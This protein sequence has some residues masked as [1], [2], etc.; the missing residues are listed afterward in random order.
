MEQTVQTFGLNA[1]A[2]GNMS[3]RCCCHTER[4]RPLQPRPAGV[5]DTVATEVLV[6]TR[7]AAA[8]GSMVL[9]FDVPAPHSPSCSSSTLPSRV[10]PA[11]L[12]PSP[13]SS[14]RP[15]PLH[16]RPFTIPSTLLVRRVAST[17]SWVS[18]SAFCVTSEESLSASLTSP[19][20]KAEAA[21]GPSLTPYAGKQRLLRGAVWIAGA[22]LTLVVAVVPLMFDEPCHVEAWEDHPIY[23][24]GITPIGYVLGRHIFGSEG[25]P[26]IGELVCVPAVA[27]W[28]TSVCHRNRSRKSHVFR[29]LKRYTFCMQ[30][31][32]LAA[33]LVPW[34]FAACPRQHLAGIYGM[35]KGGFLMTYLANQVC[36]AYM[37][38]LRLELL[39][40]D[41]AAF[42]CRVLARLFSCLA[43]AIIVM[44]PLLSM[45]VIPPWT[46]AACGAALG[47]SYIALQV[48]AICSMLQA[49]F[50]AYQEA[51]MERGSA[52]G[53]EGGSTSSYGYVLRLA[54][55][56]T[57][58]CGSTLAVIAITAVCL[59]SPTALKLAAWI[60]Q[61]ALVL[62]V[63][64]D[65]LLAALCAGV[66]GVFFD[67]EPTLLATGD[68]VEAAR[69]RQVLNALLEAAGAVTGPS[70]TLA[71]LFEGREPEQLLEAA[72]KRFRCIDWDILR[73]HAHLI[74][75]G[76]TLD[77][78]GAA[79]ELYELSKPCLLSACDAFL[80][81][82]W[83]DNGEQKWQ[84]LTEWCEAFRLAQGRSPRLW[85]DKVCIDQADI[86]SDLECLPI[87]LAGCK[88]LLVTCGSTYISRLWCCVELFVYMRMND[89]LAQDIHVCLLGRDSDE[90]AAIVDGW[91]IFDFRTCQC[92]AE[93]AK[94]RILACIEKDGGADGFNE[95]IRE[96]SASIFETRT[97]AEMQA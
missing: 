47:L 9:P 96:L 95:Y 70:V 37:S 26:I 79:T 42:Y 51:A 11:L 83:H 41:R 55:A 67:P 59:V 40:Q 18:A 57:L 20:V 60:V 54:I 52:G 8:A 62:D 91:L 15:P 36:L 31:H 58:S 75:A 17:G 94:Q 73:Q 69:R 61:F 90:E 97:R 56:S 65:A 71:A 78:V 87:F 88:A 49:T 45:G 1:T 38:V 3:L 21:N 35:L 32:S 72:V 68:L 92:F 44:H 28:L 43:P 27:Y 10:P 34:L 89:G 46:L 93:A 63:P 77:G 25:A 2:L 74:V 76:G 53:S 23:T 33:L 29:W 4:H 30:A 85:F 48:C 19:G 13:P 81:H 82:S 14:P 5:N 16:G 66:L 84:A 39:K 22:M 7:Q 64:S 24:S 12:A 6:Q 80:S 86:K 50:T